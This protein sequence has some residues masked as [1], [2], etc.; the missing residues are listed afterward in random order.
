[1]VH[2]STLLQVFRRN[3][4]KRMLR[5]KITTCLG[6]IGRMLNIASSG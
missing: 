6:I 1:V 4:R 2:E 5:R 3:I